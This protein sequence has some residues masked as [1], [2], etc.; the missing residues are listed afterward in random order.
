MTFADAITRLKALSFTGL[1]TSYEAVLVPP[2]EPELPALIIDDVSQPFVEGLRGWNIAATETQFTVFV[3]HILVIEYLWAGTH[4]TRSD[5][6]TLY[7]DRYLVAITADMYL[8]GNL[9]KPLKLIIVERGRVSVRTVNY[10]GIRIRH[11]WELK[12]T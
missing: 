7:L 1:T 3:D 10:S 12:I 9:S 2:G 6:I 11:M 4:I 8:N 5:N